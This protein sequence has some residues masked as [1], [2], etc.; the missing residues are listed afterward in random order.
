MMKTGTKIA[1]SGAAAGITAGVAA[2]MGMIL[3]G[4][5]AYKYLRNRRAEDFYSKTV[6]ITG[7]SRGLGL[8][9]AEEF[10]RQGCSIVMCARDQAELAR[11]ATGGTTR[12]GSGGCTL[13]REQPG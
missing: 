2:G 13:R 12:R 3:A 1:L 10:A 9:M 8:A 5:S 6:L 7:S 11:A 4:R